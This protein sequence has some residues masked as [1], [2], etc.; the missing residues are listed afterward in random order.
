[1]ILPVPYRLWSLYLIHRN[2][3]GQVLIFSALF[4][5]L[6]PAE[7]RVA[8]LLSD[9]LAPPAIA[10]LIGVSTN[11]LKT[12]L[13]SIY[14]KTGTSRQGQLVRMLSQLALST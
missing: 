8:L 14:R 10:D 9:G 11:K 7:C 3:Y 5:R 12:Q 13:S 6:T 1:L 4:F 2:S